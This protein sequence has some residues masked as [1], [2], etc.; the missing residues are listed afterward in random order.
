MRSLDNLQGL[1][2]IFQGKKNKNVLDNV[3]EQKMGKSYHEKYALKNAT[4]L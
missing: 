3:S 1:L 2:W 4:Q